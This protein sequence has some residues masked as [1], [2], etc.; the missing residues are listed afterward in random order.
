[1]SEDHQKDLLDSLEKQQR[2]F[3]KYQRSPCSIET[4]YTIQDSAYKDFIENISAGGVYIKTNQNHTLG[5]EV[6]M[7]FMLAGHSKSII[8]TGKIVRVSANGF[9]VKFNRELQEYFINLENK[10]KAEIR[11]MK[12]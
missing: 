4:D 5:Q 12:P 6:T 9:A 2:G 11:Q 7:T 3:R 10:I 8:V 1:M